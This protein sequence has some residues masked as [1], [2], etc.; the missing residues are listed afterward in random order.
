MNPKTR[1]LSTVATPNYPSIPNLNRSP[2]IRFVY[3]GYNGMGRADKR[4]WPGA[5]SRC[6]TPSNSKRIGRLL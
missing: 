3:G 2:K 4:P 5:E 6:K 1:E